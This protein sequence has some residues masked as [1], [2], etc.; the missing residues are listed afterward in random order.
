M[1]NRFSH[2]EL[3]PSAQVLERTAREERPLQ[4]ATL[5]ELEG[6]FEPALERYSR[7]LRHDPTMAEAWAGQVRC[8]VALEEYREARVWAQKAATVL[9]AAAETHSAL[10][11]ALVH[12][13]RPEEGLSA[14]DAALEAPAGEACARIWLERACCLMALDRWPAAEACLDK[15]GESRQEPDWQQRQAVEYLSFGR[16]NAGVRLLVEVTTMRP[17]RAYAWLLLGRGYR[18][19]GQGAASERAF[20]QAEQL[21][22]EWGEAILRERRRA[23]GWPVWILNLMTLFKK[24]GA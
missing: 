21:S 5:A 16:P 6:R 14:S 12:S 8:L 3:T 11:Y 20:A 13:G 2:L 9:P 19:L 4:V 23:M 24:K 18:A 22:P 10:A 17:D 1:S 7:A 15:L